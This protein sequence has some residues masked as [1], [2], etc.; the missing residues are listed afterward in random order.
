MAPSPRKIV[1]VKASRIGDFLCA[2]PS[3]RALRRAW[4][5]AEI[6]LVTLALLRGLAKRLPYIDRVVDF[7]GYPGL[8]EQLFSPRRALAFFAR[9]Q[10]ERFDLAIQLQGSGVYSNPVAL[11]LGAR[12]TAGFIRP[13]DGPGRLDVAVTWP[14]RGHEIDRILALPRALGAGM[15]GRDV[16]LTLRQ[17]DYDRAADLLGT[18]PP[19][20]VGVHCGAHGLARRWRLSLYAGVA[21]HLTANGGSVVLLGGAAD[22]AAA[23]ALSGQLAAWPL[24]NLAGRT[25]LP[26]LG[27]ALAF[28]RVLVAND[29]GPAHL[30]YAVGT[31][32]VTLC[33][34]DEVE[35]Y[36][37]PA[38]P[39]RALRPRGGTIRPEC[40]IAAA[41]ELL[42]SRTPPRQLRS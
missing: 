18:L 37:P 27:A 32:T 41:T 31:P 16:G 13:G 35:R 10:A 38:G 5:Q 28:L 8:A 6:V 15:A 40:V 34:T 9:M 24:I 4:P 29:S 2:A 42:S 25:T 1:V 21:R 17:A 30:A 39:F 33:L 14:E 23:R 19:P 3:L 20:Y 36:G 12:H 22:I 7:P 26:V 11:M